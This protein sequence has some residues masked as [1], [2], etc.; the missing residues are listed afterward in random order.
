LVG[1]IGKGSN[2]LNAKIADYCLPEAIQALHNL[3]DLFGLKNGFQTSEAL[4]IW[5]RR[6]ATL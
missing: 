1:V 4:M 5:H 6:A 3:I 2:V